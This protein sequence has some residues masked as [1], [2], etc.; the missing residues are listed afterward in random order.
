MNADAV[1]R[2]SIR[3]AK[4]QF[5]PGILNEFN[6]S[7]T[8]SYVRINRKGSEH[9]IDLRRTLDRI[10]LEG[11]D[12]LVYDLSSTSVFTIRPADIL[13]GIFKLPVDLLQDAKV[14][15][16]DPLGDKRAVDI[17]SPKL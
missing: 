10:G 16:H 17:T 3:L 6:N 4:E 2:F 13:K 1:Q 15:K 14:V 5:D 12:T 8:W 9:R 7:D 11:G